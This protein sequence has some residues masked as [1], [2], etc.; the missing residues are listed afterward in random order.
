MPCKDP[1]KAMSRAPLE[2]RQ[3]VICGNAFTPKR[4][5][6]VCC[7]ES[8]KAQRLR[9]WHR[10]FY[11]R[12]SAERLGEMDTAG[13]CAICGKPFRREMRTQ[14]CCSDECRAA[15][16][17]QR[18]EVYNKARREKRSHER[19]AK[20]VRCLRCRFPATKHKAVM[21]LQGLSRQ[22]SG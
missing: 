14:V 20:K 21:L 18:M 12:E 3:C 17:Y 7:S 5:N 15:R 11:A 16:W 1:G 6:E 2:P 4:K 8:C 10:Q 19:C 9:D 13:I 22:K